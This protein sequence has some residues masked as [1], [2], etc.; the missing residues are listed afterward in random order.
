[1]RILAVVIAGGRGTRLYP[2]T[3]YRSKPAIPFGGRY[4]IIDFVLSNLVNSG[5]HSIYVLTQF[6]SQSLSEHLASGWHFGGILSDYFV[7]PVPAQM[8]ID[9][10][11]YKGTADA[12]FQNLHLIEE[13]RPDLVAVFG[14][15]HVYRMDVRKMVEFHRARGADLTVAALPVPIEYATEFGIIEVDSRWKMVNFV[16]KPKRPTHIPGDNAHALCSLGNYLVDPRALVEEL[17]ADSTRDSE[18][19]FGRSIIPAMLG[20]REVHVYDFRQNRIPEPKKGEE[21]SYWRD[22]GTIESYF[23]ANMDLKA[24][25]PVFNLYNMVWPIRT[26]PSGLPPAKFVFDEEKRR[27]VAIDSLLSEGCIVSGGYVR[28]S[29]LGRSVFVHSYAR[30]EESII[31]HDVDIGRHCQ[32]RRAII[33]SM[34]KVPPRTRIGYDLEEDGKRFRVSDQGIV[35]VPKTFDDW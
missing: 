18:H 28:D 34:V 17:R 15:D 20:R 12:V 9:G 25:D 27:G 7:T 29:I 32:I 3:K 19:D 31:F 8:Q 16:E 14:A 5:I 13:F 23:E 35:V 6:K 2:L 1:V 4:R 30:V 21:H 26:S 33:D 24:V 11:W 22:I 10:S